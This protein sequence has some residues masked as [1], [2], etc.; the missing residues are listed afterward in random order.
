MQEPQPHF[1]QDRAAALDI[2]LVLADAEARWRDYERALDL[3]N[4]A[5]NAGCILSPEYRM[6]RHFWD[7]ELAS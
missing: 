4:E 1:D 2:L 5:E 7:A 3:L 6:K